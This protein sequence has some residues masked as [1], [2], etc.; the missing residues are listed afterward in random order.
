VAS[1]R[2]TSILLAAV[3]LGAAGCGGD[4]DPQSGE[5]EQM[6]AFEE[7]RTAQLEKLV[8]DGVVPPV[9]T[10][11]YNPNGTLNID[12]IDG[13]NGDNDVVRTSE[14]GASGKKLAWDLDQ[15][16]KIERSE[17]TI[18]ER[19]LYDATLGYH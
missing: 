9:A 17:R 19:E 2:L 18:T 11:L 3:V 16:G 4:D 15:D 5:V 14:D 6:K 1:P 7:T 10:R 8:S 13:P 12:F